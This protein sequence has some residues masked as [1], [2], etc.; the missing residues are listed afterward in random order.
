[1]TSAINYVST[2][3]GWLISRMDDIF[4]SIPGAF[5][6]IISIFAVYL[7]VR[8]LLKPIFGGSDKVRKSKGEDDNG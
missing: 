3:F 7:S 6:L 2:A 1:M 4:V 8:L 5:G